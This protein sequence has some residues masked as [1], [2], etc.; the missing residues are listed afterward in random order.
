MAKTTKNKRGRKTQ[1]RAKRVWKRIGVT[2]LVAF[3][4]AGLTGLGGFV[5]LYQSTDLPDANADFNTNTT[6]L[7]YN[8][9]TTQLG[10]LAVQN[11][12]TIDYEQMPQLMKDAVVAAENRS[13]WD[14]PGIS[15]T[16]IARSAISIATGGELQ[17][18]STITQQYIKIYYLDSGQRLSRKV[19]ELMLAI[20]MGRELTKEQIL[21]GYLNTIYFGRG[22]YGIQAAAKS[23]FLKDSREL[24]LEEAAALAAI[25]NN[26]A[27]FNPSGGEEKLARLLE[28]YRYVLGGML[29]MGT[30]TQAD[31]DRAAAALPAFPEVPVNNR[32]GGTKGF[33]I[34][35]VEDELADKGFTEAEI[36][37][38]GLKIVTTVD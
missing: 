1:S 31:H 35:Q 11:R 17:G 2:A 29:A 23:Y 24:T 18:G 7:Y 10:S 27:G 22:A 34:K 37:G 13:F 30:I 26:P 32:Y 15:I 3:I 16:G 25:L 20:K 19:K 12:V 8:D 33:L 9:E 38:G 4:I 36:Q 21:E 14:D 28:R 5:W 6:F